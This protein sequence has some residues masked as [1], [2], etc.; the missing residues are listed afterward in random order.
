MP[1]S[2]NADN[3]AVADALERYASLLDLA[4]SSPHAVR[5]YRRA[6]ELIR[7]LPT[8]VVDLVRSGKVRDLRGIGPSLEARLRELVETGE[9]AD[10]R[11]LEREVEPGLVGLGRYLGL[12]PKQAVAAGRALGARTAAE[13]REAVESGRIKDVPGMGPKSAAK[14][15]EALEPESEP[16][17]PRGL[18]L[19]T[20]RELSGT[21][22]TELDGVATGD[23]RR[24]SAPSRGRP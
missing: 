11:E 5:A 10:A 24:S 22:A 18:L 23:S 21:L 4:G 16:R 19:H 2:L 17:A 14:L 20:A 15:R 1:N 9:I 8:P 3:Q 6:A 7:T 12:S 13:L